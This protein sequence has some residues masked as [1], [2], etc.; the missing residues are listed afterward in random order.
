[1]IGNAPP[2]F[3]LITDSEFCLRVNRTPDPL[4]PA[5]GQGW[6]ACDPCGR[7]LYDNCTYVL[8]PSQLY[9]KAQ[10]ST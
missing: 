1:M 6:S 3:F 5:C 8:L 4:L 2:K 10:L 7:I 9:F